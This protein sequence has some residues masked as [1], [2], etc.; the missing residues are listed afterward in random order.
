MMVFMQIR[1]GVVPPGILHT[2]LHER[3]QEKD[4]EIDKITN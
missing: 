3:E 1:V 2:I 4:C